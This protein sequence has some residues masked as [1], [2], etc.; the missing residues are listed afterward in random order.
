MAQ[1]FQEAIPKLSDSQLAEYITDHN[2]YRIEAVE[3]AVIEL[4][5][6]GKQVSDAEFQQ[7]RE[8]IAQRDRERQIAREAHD[9]SLTWKRHVT[10]DPSAPLLYSER[11]IYSLSLLFSVLFGAVLLVLNLRELKKP[12]GVIPAMSFAIAYLATLFFIFPIIQSAF[13]NFQVSWLFTYL[14][15]WLILKLVW[16]K[17]IG[18]DTKYRK[19]SI[20]I[21]VIIGLI[22]AGIYLFTV[23]SQTSAR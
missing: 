17:Y 16:A 10:D 12:E 15:A 23:F 6:R 8:A 7:M 3:C 9:P 4:R 18:K 1:T 11:A 21:P 22:I 19:R 14:G 20:T 13:G 2:R 5:K